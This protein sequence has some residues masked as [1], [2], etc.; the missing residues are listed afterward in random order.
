M[1]NSFGPGLL[2]ILGRAAPVHQELAVLVE[3]R[4][5]RAAVAV[6][7]EERAVG[8][9]VDIGGP[10]E[11]LAAIA[12][13]LALGAERHHQLAVI[14]ELV[15]D[16]QLVVEHP[17]VLLGIVRA[18][19][20]L[21]WS[22]PAGHL[23]EFV[24]LRPRLDHL[25]G[26]IHDED[27]VVIAS[28]PAALLR[29]GSHVAPSPSSLPVALPRDGLSS[30]YGVHGFAPA[31]SGNSPRCAIQMRSGVSAYTAPTDPHVQPSC[32]TPSGPS[33]SGCGQFGTSSYGPNSSCPPFSWSECH[34]RGRQDEHQ[35]HHQ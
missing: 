33:G 34:C 2:R 3:L 32:L 4:D 25:A 24:V 13:S 23:E 11:E 9:P 27:D 15:D 16:V 29:V 14:G 30:A 19:L 31:G 8:Q 1:L 12:P 26:A 35:E 10:I 5:A 18:H 21:V 22:A 6:A 28:L 20:D 17:D 7:D